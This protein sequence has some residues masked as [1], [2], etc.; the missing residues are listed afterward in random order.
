MTFQA[1]QYCMRT[2]R[3]DY[4]RKGHLLPL[5]TRGT[6]ASTLFKFSRRGDLDVVRVMV[7]R[8]AS[9]CFRCKSK[10]S[11][12]RATGMFESCILSFAEDGLNV[13]GRAIAAFAAVTCAF[14]GIVA[15]PVRSSVRTRSMHAAATQIPLSSLTFMPARNTQVSL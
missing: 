11:I 4:C 1:L 9:A 8:G 5:G 12:T 15:A 13:N 3:V 14:V 2:S 10:A 7:R 6:S